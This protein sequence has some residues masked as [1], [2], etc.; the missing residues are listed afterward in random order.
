MFNH[1]MTR[2]AYRPIFFIM[3][4]SGI[5]IGSIIGVTFALLD[6]TAI[7]ILGGTFIALLTGL[8]SGFLAIIYTAVFNALAPTIGG[9]VLELEQL[10]VAS[11]DNPNLQS[12]DSSSH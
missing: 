5:C 6:R 10:P 4:V 1:T 3:F 8:G 2:L 12:P 7:G 11:K 9:I